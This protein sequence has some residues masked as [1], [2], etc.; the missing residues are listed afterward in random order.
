MAKADTLKRK[1]YKDLNSLGRL[2]ALV[3]SRSV[4]DN[5]FGDTNIYKKRVY[6]NKN[7]DKP[8]KIRNNS[9]NLKFDLDSEI[10][11]AR[12]A[13]RDEIM[14]K[15]KG[16]GLKVKNALWNVASFIQCRD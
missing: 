5:R 2:D 3:L 12:K 4:P 6:P 1:R 9:I 11:R 14:K 13:R 16:K 7:L 8:S 15:T 10:C